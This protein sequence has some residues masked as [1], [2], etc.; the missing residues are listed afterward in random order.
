[1]IDEIELFEKL[2]HIE[3][4]LTDLKMKLK[5]SM[6]CAHE[7][8]FELLMNKLEASENKDQKSPTNGNTSFSRLWENRINK[9]TENALLHRKLVREFIARN[10]TNS[11][12]SSVSPSSLYNSYLF[13]SQEDYRMFMPKKMF[14][15]TLLS[16]FHDMI[17][18]Q[19]RGK[20][21]NIIGLRPKGT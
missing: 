2:E 3:K 18:V 13:Q 15:E 16:V 14:L 4:D 7:G 11:R 20:H 5:E 6:A 12:T 10:Y 17:T 9:E 19:G 21:M 8:K 1:M